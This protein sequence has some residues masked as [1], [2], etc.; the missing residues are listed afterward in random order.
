[1]KLFNSENWVHMCASLS[2][3]LAAL[4]VVGTV[5]GQVAAGPAG[6]ANGWM[7][8]AT[9]LSQ[10]E[11]VSPAIRQQR[12]S[13][14]D[15]SPL[16]SRVPLTPGS[17]PLHHVFPGAH[18][19]G[20]PEIAEVSDRAVV[21]ATF[22]GHR[23][24]LTASGRE[25]YTEITFHVSSVFQDVSGRAVRD[26]DITVA[27]RGGTVKTADGKVISYLTD[28]RQYFIQP[29]R[30]YLLVL[31]H[32]ADGDFY[33]LAGDWDISDGVVRVNSKVGQQ[34]SKEGKSTLVGL[35]TEQLIH[36]LEERLAAK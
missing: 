17:A 15:A 14:F 18:V 23:S 35:T 20:Q 9:D 16:A 29:Q 21:I 11:T 33:S 3:S 1:M 27:L 22:T 10:L 32:H 8:I 34:R 36:A 25:V 13:H 26:S 30:T 7:K 31:S 2:L 24:V 28:P 4:L 5:V 6:A 19:A 12:D